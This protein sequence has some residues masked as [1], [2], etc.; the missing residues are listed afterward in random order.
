MLTTKTVR[1]KLVSE[2]FR[3]GRTDD[4]AAL[5][6][7]NIAMA[8]ETENRKLDRDVVTAGVLGLI[9]D[10]SRGFYMVAE[11][12]GVVVAGLMVTFEW[13]DWRNGTFWWIQS[14]Y[15]LP[16]CRRQGVFTRLYRS[17]EAMAAERNNVCGLRLYVEQNNAAAQATYRGL[18][19]DETHYDM[20]E[21][22]FGE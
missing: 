22:E 4:V 3:L 12:N 14:V 15:V 10:P 21:V 9:G 1:K 19:M 2:T 6:E 11:V 13:S 5:T 16:A 18:G 20:Y 8:R 7:F 17:V